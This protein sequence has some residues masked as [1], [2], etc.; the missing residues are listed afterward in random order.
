VTGTSALPTS[1][2][3]YQDSGGTG[4]HV[5]PRA[6][7]GARVLL[8]ATLLAAPLA[9]GAVQTWAWA[10]ISISALLMLLL[11]A[12]GCVRQG[13]I[14]IVWS[15]L[16]VPAALFVLLGTAQ[17]YGR[18]TLD[19]IA[20]REAL[21]K[22]VA[23]LIVFFLAG[24]LF[25]FASPRVWGA[26]GLTVTLFAFALALFAILQFFS[27]GGTVYW[28]VKP[29]RWGGY[30][31]GPYI[32]HNHYAGLMEMLIPIAAAFVL[33]C[34]ESQSW[35]TLLRFSVLVAVA[36]LLLSGSRGGMI[37]LLGEILILSAV[38]HKFSRT[39][40]RKAR[41]TLV[42]VGIVA[43]AL[44]FFWMDPGE[45]SKR[46]T[47]VANLAQSPEAT[48]GERKMVAI[49]SLRIWRDHPWLGTGLGSFETAY[50]R[51]R[52]FPGDAVYDHAHNDYAEALAETGLVG[53]VLILA[54]IVLFFRIAFR[55]LATRLRHEV[56][57]IQL[58]AALG[59][60]GLL[61]HSLVDFNLHIPAN[62]AWFAVSAAI[63]TKV[64]TLGNR[65]PH[66]EAGQSNQLENRA[67]PSPDTLR[68]A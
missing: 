60:C 46:L 54:A 37:A 5:E 28:A 33:S 20:T 7:L 58:G 22:L 18:L 25:A 67:G 27:S 51:Y 23:Y 62:V 8:I 26:L 66:G 40:G 52:S 30:V 64:Y 14:R 29:P 49:D 35:R 42:G 13:V 15:P 10:A 57:W 11:W 61:I 32:N 65:F 41:A 2:S 48:L 34:R 12:L 19:A 63:A 47:T 45:V 39:P 3:V 31:F 36:A 38:V 9:F 16:Y 50:P 17:L 4:F 59:C 53:G 6:F 44:L 55:D 21:I 24:Q 1:V 56:G 43:A 68:R